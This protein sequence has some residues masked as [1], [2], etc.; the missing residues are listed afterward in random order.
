VPLRSP[1][2]RIVTQEVPEEYGERCAAFSLTNAT[3]GAMTDHDRITLI[4]SP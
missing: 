2:K 3:L 1:T 4:C